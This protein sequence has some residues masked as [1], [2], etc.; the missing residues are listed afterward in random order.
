[1]A[2]SFGYKLP[3]YFMEYGPIQAESEDMARAEIRKRLGVRRLPWG[4]QVWD[5]ANRPLARWK[6]DQAS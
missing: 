4:L 6:V 1:M 5:L 3:G 2:K